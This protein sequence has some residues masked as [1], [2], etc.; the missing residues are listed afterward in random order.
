MD[1]K[2]MGEFLKKLRNEK[3]ITQEQLAEMLNVSNRSISRWENGRN[4]PD[5]DILLLLCEY[6]DVEMSELLKGERKE[7]MKQEEKDTI[8]QVVDYGNKEKEILTRRL[9]YFFIAGVI[10]LF[11][12][13]LIEFLEFNHTPFISFITGFL[14]GA[15]LGIL[16]LGVLY[17]SKCMNK[18]RDRKLKLFEKMKSF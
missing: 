7:E 5:I 18:L 11:I 17:T 3:N 8:L 16:I 6:Y 15:S 1:Q 14:Q 9:H 4:L 12:N 2:K 13:L 10:C